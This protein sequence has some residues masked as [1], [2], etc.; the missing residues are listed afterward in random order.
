MKESI[1]D[2]D[3][4]IRTIP[5]GAKVEVVTKATAADELFDAWY[6]KAS[7][8]AAK[9]DAAFAQFQRINSAFG[10]PA[11]GKA[12]AIRYPAKVTLL[13]PAWDELL[14]SNSKKSTAK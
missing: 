7:T 5:K 11:N 12:G 4:W 2:E 3:R 10:Q 14:D 1:E 13:R 6:P 8:D 9:R